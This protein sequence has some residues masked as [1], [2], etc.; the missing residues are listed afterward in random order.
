[1]IPNILKLGSAA[2]LLEPENAREILA[3]QIAD[4]AGVYGKKPTKKKSGG[5]KTRY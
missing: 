3:Q 2:E 5:T 1:V 4:M